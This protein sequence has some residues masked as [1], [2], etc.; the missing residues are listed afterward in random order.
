MDIVLLSIGKISTAWIKEGSNNF[1]ARLSRYIKCSFREIPDLKNSKNLSKDKI[2]EEEGKLILNELTASDLVA[3]MDEHGKEFTSRE[4]AGW[5][6]KSLTSGKK[7]L[8]FIIG[9]PYGFS[10]DVYQRADLKISLSKMT[11]THEMAKLFLTE[12]LYRAFTIL[13]GEPYHH[14]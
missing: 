2:K 8:V 9:G 7:R 3:I 6:E 4:L 12:Q 11:F 5:I 14:D 1:E 10:K 13:N